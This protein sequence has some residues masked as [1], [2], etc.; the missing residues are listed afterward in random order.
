MEYAI[1]AILIC[2]S[3]L[4]SGLTLGLLGLNIHHLKRQARLGNAHATRI[5]PIREHGNQLLSALLLGNVLVN[6]ILSIYLGSIA[7]GV[8]A[9]TAATALIFIFGEI[10]PQAAFARHAL[11]FGSL[12]VPFVHLWLWVTWPITYPLG[13]IL[14][15]LLGKELP[16]M[17]SKQELME[18]VSELEDSPGSPID[19]DEERIVHGALK[20]SH[21]KVCEVMTSIPAVRSFMA[22][23]TLN[24]TLRHDIIATGHSRFPVIERDSGHVVGILYTKDVLI[25]PKHITVYE[26]AEHSYLRVHPLET[27]DTILAHMLRRK[28]HMGVVLDA[29][30]TM[31]GVITMEDIIEEVIQ[32]EII[33][34]DD[35][36]VAVRNGEIVHSVT[37]PLSS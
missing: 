27:L 25:E 37:T 16:M 15:R 20:F 3:A 23:D 32:Q 31:V 8:V 7:T 30:D 21:T 29:D 28:Q 6:S 19:R 13:R 36:V 35:H 24:D 33:D 22:S 1:S 9:A 18:I 10:L 34:E 26:A 5:V 12:F 17:Y 4:F 14:D 2:F 11:R